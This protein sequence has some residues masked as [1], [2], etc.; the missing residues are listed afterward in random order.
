MMVHQHFISH[1]FC[2]NL[3]DICQLRWQ[4]YGSLNCLLNYREL[5]GRKLNVAVAVSREKVGKVCRPQRGELRHTV[6]LL[7]AAHSGA[8]HPRWMVCLKAE[9]AP[10]AKVGKAGNIPPCIKL[11][12]G[13]HLV[14]WL[15]PDVRIGTSF[16]TKRKRGALWISHGALLSNPAWFPTV[17]YPLFLPQ[18]H[19]RL[20]LQVQTAVC[21]Q[22]CVR[23]QRPLLY[24]WDVLLKNPA[25]HFLQKTHNA[26]FVT[27]KEIGAPRCETAFAVLEQLE[28]SLWECQ[29]CSGARAP[30]S[31]SETYFR[32]C[33]LF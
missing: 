20:G 16:L 31:P 17:A 4:P 30:I 1:N 13:A 8:V 33:L 19:E 27:N 15:C 22:N 11:Q 14:G 25:K 10:K 9:I 6:F 12:L 29:V 23:F 24:N 18:S 26:S 21:A 2:F 32:R 3:L 28:G 5:V 7:P